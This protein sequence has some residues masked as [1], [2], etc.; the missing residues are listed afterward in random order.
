MRKILP[1]N[2][3]S[4][5]LGTMKITR[6]SPLTKLYNEMD[7]DV[8]QDQINRFDKPKHLREPIQ[9]IFPN[10]SASEREFLKTGY[11]DEDWKQIFGPSN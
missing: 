7:L 2:K 8:T 5:I 1:I 9:D 11:T 3:G 10:L 6:R 4:D